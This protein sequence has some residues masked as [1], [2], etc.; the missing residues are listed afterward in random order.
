MKRPNKKV[1]SRAKITLKSPIPPTENATS[2]PTPR[3]ETLVRIG[4]RWARAKRQSTTSVGSA[5]TEVGGE[6]L[7]PFYH[8]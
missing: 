2:G 6:S 4:R 8:L 3:H 1:S 7:G 5:L